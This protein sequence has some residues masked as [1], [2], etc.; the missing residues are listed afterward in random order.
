MP[1]AG[2]GSNRPREPMCQVSCRAD[3]DMVMY[4]WMEAA[5][6]AGMTLSH[7]MR[8]E[9]GRAAKVELDGDVPYP[10]P[11]E[12]KRK[13]RRRR[14]PADMGLDTLMAERRKVEGRMA[15]LLRK[16]GRIDEAEAARVRE[17]KARSRIA[18]R[19]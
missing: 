1:I 8:E 12:A 2:K 6:K 3:G 18:D 19:R 14:K 7:W 13:R 15:G 10:R 5:A 9:L 4:G 17:L 16:L 11:P